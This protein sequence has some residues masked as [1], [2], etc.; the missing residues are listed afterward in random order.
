MSNQEKHDTEEEHPKHIYCS[1]Y[2]LLGKL[3]SHRSN[4][5]ARTAAGYMISESY[6]LG[7]EQAPLLLPSFTPD[8]LRL[9]SLHNFIVVILKT[10]K[11]F[12]LRE[13]D[14]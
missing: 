4:I 2:T 11:A 6:F 13:T 14:T 8:L 9:P 3:L 1:T 10:I 12:K 5:I 7:N